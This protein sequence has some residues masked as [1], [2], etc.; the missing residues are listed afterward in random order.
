[1]PERSVRSW[2]AM[3]AG[4]VQWKN[5]NEALRLFRDMETTGMQPNEVTVVAVLAACADLGELD[6]AKRIHAFAMQCSLH[7]NNVRVCNTL[8]DM[9]IKCGCLQLAR[10]VFDEMAERTVVSWSAMIG[11]HAMHGQAE[12]ALELFSKMEEAS[13]EPNAVTFVGLL[14]ACSH[15]GL[16]QEGRQFFRS[17][18]QDYGIVPEIEHYGCMVDLLSRA[19][20]LEEAREFIN[21]MP[22][23]PNS[24]VW[25][26]LL[27]GAKVHKNIKMGEEAIHNLMELD[28]RNDGYYVVLSNIYADAE[29]WEDVAKIRRM[30]KDRGLKK[31]PGWSTISLD[32]VVHS[33]VAGE[34]DH[35][36]IEEIHRSLDELLEKL[37]HRGYVP[38][39]SAVLLDMDEKNKERVLYHHSEKLAAAYGLMNTANGTPIRIM[40]NLRVCSDC[41]AALK[42]ISEITN[43]EIVV[44]DRNRGLGDAAGRT[45]LGLASISLSHYIDVATLSS[46]AGTVDSSNDGS[47]VVELKAN[48]V[49][50]RLEISHPSH[51]PWNGMGR[52]LYANLNYV[53]AMGYSSRLMHIMSLQ[54][55]LDAASVIFQHNVDEVPRLRV[56][57]LLEI[58]NVVRGINGAGTMIVMILGTDQGLLISVMAA[59]NL[60]EQVP[61]LTGFLQLEIMRIKGGSHTSMSLLPTEVMTH[62]CIYKFVRVLNG[63]RGGRLNGRRTSTTLSLLETVL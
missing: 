24:V 29:R 50:H 17:M 32:G 42:L 4:Y 56:E 5:P 27:G 35:P 53:Q 59:T 51:Y 47:T 40:K 38:D 61:G 18:T 28:P 63:G 44:R 34:S 26:A 55:G 8:I 58:G 7:K 36:Q 30:M 52:S 23:E 22:I 1:M 60:I 12:E 6:L 14:H 41:H 57:F 3:I 2:T 13:V 16:L 31:T 43:R 19:G 46:N 48:E 37:R 25:G 49:G 62:I 10:Q 20:L 15:I 21:K 33:F 9:Y 54:S 39:T 11:G 45:R